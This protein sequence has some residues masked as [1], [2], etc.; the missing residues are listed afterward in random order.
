MNKTLITEKKIKLLEAIIRSHYNYCQNKSGM[1]KE[2]LRDIENLKALKKQHKRNYGNE[3]L[4]N[5]SP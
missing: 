4:P 5:K 1:D 2:Q 3:I